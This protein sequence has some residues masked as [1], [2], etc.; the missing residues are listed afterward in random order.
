MYEAPPSSGVHPFPQRHR[1]Q[2][3][4]EKTVHVIVDNY[5][6]HKH[7]DVLEWLAR[8][9][10]FV[11]HFTPTSASWLNA[12]RGDP[13]NRI[14]YRGRQEVIY[15][16]TRAEQQRWRPADKRMI[17]KAL[18]RAE[19]RVL[20]VI[21]ATRAAHPSWLRHRMA[22][23]P[24]EQAHRALKTEGKIIIFLPVRCRNGKK[25]RDHPAKFVRRDQRRAFDDDA[26]VAS[27]VRVAAV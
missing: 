6:A 3:A 25:R 27:I 5:A 13:D 1:G 24:A 9:P 7:P 16:C 11:F 23:R 26:Q 12:E 18:D 8:H 2:S 10:R 20:Q 4:S 14:R 15:A 17:I 21:N 22:L 19:E